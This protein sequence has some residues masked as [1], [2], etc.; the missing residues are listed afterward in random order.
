M[1]KYFNREYNS[2]RGHLSSLR[3]TLKVGLRIVIPWATGILGNLKCS[4]T[5]HLEG[6]E[7]GAGQRREEMGAVFCEPTGW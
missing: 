4:L 2:S 5:L 3:K 7:F 6:E 1:K